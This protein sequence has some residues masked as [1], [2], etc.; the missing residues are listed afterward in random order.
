LVNCWFED[1]IADPYALA[2]MLAD[3]PGIAEHGLF[4]DMATEVV[5][6]GADG[7]RVLERV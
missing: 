3:R 1:G 4:L 6:A 2:R 5:V 7:I